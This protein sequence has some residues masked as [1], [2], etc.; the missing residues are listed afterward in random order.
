MLAIRYP[1]VIV[2]PYTTLPCMPQIEGVLERITYQSPENGYTVARLT[3]QD[4]GYLITIVGN[5]A[6]IS[7]GET[8]AIE[9]E[10]VEHREH[11]RQF[12]VHSFRTLMPATIDGIRRYLGSGLIKGIGPAT[13]KRI[14]E[15]FGKYT[16]DVL[17]HAP[18]R[19]IEVP[20]LGRKKVEQIR[21]AWQAQQRIK[22]VMLVL[23]ELGLTPGLAVRIYKH[24][25]DDALE[26]VRNAPYRLA[27]EVYG[28]GFL[29]A[30][31]IARGLGVA[32]D[33]PQR[34]GAGLRYAL[35]QATE[36]G[37][38]YLPAEELVTKA[39]ELLEIPPDHADAVLNDPNIMREVVFGAQQQIYLAPLAYA[40]QGVA[41][42]LA[43][44]ARATSP[45]LRFYRDANWSRVFA[46]LAERRDVNL[47]DRQQAAVRMALTQ[48]VSV[49]TGGPGTGKTTCLH[50]LVTLLQA[51]GYQPALASPTGRAAK[52]LSE[53]TGLAAKTI[54]RLLEYSPQGGP[55]FK[56]N[57][58]HPLECDLLVIDEVSMLDIVLANQLLKA[59]P[60][61]AHLLLVGDADQLPSVGPGRV[62]RDLIESGAVPSVHL[63]TI[64]RQAEGSGIALNAQLINEGALPQLEG[65]DDF[66][67]FGAADAE[68]CAA[69]TVELVLERIPRRF[70]FDPRRDIQVL[71]PM[72]RGAAGVASLNQQLQ[73]SLNPAQP[74]RHEK[75]YGS[76]LFRVGDRVMQQRNNYDLDVYN[77]DIGTIEAISHDEELLTLRLDDQRSVEYE[78]DQL[79]EL[80]HAYALSIHK[81]QG[82]EYP[83]VVVPLMMQHYALLQ[84]NLLYTAITR[85]RKLVVLVGDRRAV[86]RAV[87]NN[88]VVERYS[89]LRE[90]LQI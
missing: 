79:D 30:D 31:R 56:R 78:F 85:A 15:T 21:Q 61:E 26:M 43:R 74:G 84:R 2:N 45:M 86:A 18:Q 54:H 39:S 25:G 66:F 36:E 51:R 4:K 60:P 70:G 40:E 33:D 81:S 6:G 7:P 47:T 23:Q 64:F 57:A 53:T 76:T 16:I 46:Y 27:D 42:T 14:T 50:T 63:D 20:S 58:D 12:E 68:R 67:F 55:H 65:L 1:L 83:V 35:S 87:E 77:G 13:A 9:G 22:E 28:I 3:L 90:R 34:I 48:K 73:T 10:W 80:S 75:H 69:L 62:L 41:S 5:L 89:G 24:Y 19:L 72:H 17:D 49:L 37:H 88:Q 59:V 29:T 44:L 11:G 8:L 71:S 82:G 32:V 38:C 52:R